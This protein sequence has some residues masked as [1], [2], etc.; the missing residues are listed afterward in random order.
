[1]KFKILFVVLL[2]AGAVYYIYPPKEKINLGLDLQGGIHMVLQVEMKDAM[3]AE[4]DNSKS[5]L[6]RILKDEKVDVKQVKANPEQLKIMVT[7][8]SE[9]KVEKTEKIFD[10]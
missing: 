6:E 10:D 4:L 5:N 1:M 8:V 2:T 9:D 7:G 3:K